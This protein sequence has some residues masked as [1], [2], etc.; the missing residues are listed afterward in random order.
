MAR[1]HDTPTR[2]TA[3][4]VEYRQKYSLYAPVQ[5]KSSRNGS[6]S[7]SDDKARKEREGTASR[8]SADPSTGRRR[9]TMRSKEHDDE[10]EQLRRALEESKR[11]TAPANGRRAG[12]RAREEN[13]E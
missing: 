9:G 13:E 4:R 7:K 6:V 5:A 11:E 10:E 3:K 8:A 2:I 1:Y 12:K